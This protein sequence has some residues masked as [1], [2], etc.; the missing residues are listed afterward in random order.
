MKYLVLLCLFAAPAFAVN[1]PC[2]QTVG[3]IAASAVLTRVSGISPLLV[4]FDAT[5]TTYSGT[6]AGANNA[7]QDLSYTWNFGDT[8]GS[9]TSTWTYG[10]RP[11][12]N[13]RNVA[14]GAIAAH[15]YV[16]EGRDTKYTATLTVTDGTTTVSCG[17]GATAFDPAGAKGF[18]TTATTC[19]FNTTVGSGCPA[20]A[21]QTAT[22]STSSITS[23]M[24]TKRVLFKCGDT[25]TGGATFGGTKFS[26]GAYG[27]CENTQTNRPIFT[28][29]NALTVNNGTVVDGRV[30]DIDFEGPGSGW[31]ISTTGGTPDGPVT[32]Y[33]LK[34]N[35]YASSYYWAQGTQ[36]AL[37]NSVM[38]GET[39]IGV[40][41]NYAQ[42]NCVNGS[43]VYNC[44]GTPS[45]NNINYQAL[46]GNNLNGAGAGAGNVENTRISACRFCVISYNTFQNSGGGGAPLKFHNGNTFN[47]NCEWMGQWTEYTVISDNYLTGTNTAAQL[48]E[49]GPQNGVTD[50]RV[51]NIIIERNVFN[52][53]VP[54]QGRALLLN[55]MN[56][57]VRDNAFNLSTQPGIQGI[58]IAK[59]GFEFSSNNTNAP[60][61]PCAGT[62]T[63]SAPI[64]ASAPQFDEIYNNSFYHNSA[65]AIAFSGTNFTAPG[66]NGFAKN[67]LD[68]SPSAGTIITNAGSGNI[69]TPNTTTITNNPGF[70]NGSGTL[71]V[72]SDFK[73]TANFTGGTSVPVWYDA[74][75]VPW[76]PTWD[77]GAVH[78]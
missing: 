47:T 53:L 27:G 3:P 28:G 52:P 41:V 74:L 15:L 51:R 78:H 54:T 66:N 59:R 6:L 12:V 42:N 57:T 24:N 33:N 72:I 7:F 4:F 10:S 62:G 69:V 8:L 30:S 77:L 43:A 46:L 22:S 61:A 56:A 63:T 11:N 25:F 50:E 49:V 44:G 68:Y 21:T 1:G 32:L 71:T 17:V 39:T 37:V 65:A 16:T 34:S 14:T 40:F 38:T 73:P 31:A 55:A 48:M 18:P 23:T 70:T 64:N 35:G 26:I 76:S 29:A 36:W 5:G 58:Q 2:P 20:G 67:N 13:S 19:L 60:G 9:G 75:G 45:F